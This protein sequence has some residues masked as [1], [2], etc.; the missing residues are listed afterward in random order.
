MRRNSAS[1]AISSCLC[2]SKSWN[3]GERATVI[4]INKSYQR[5]DC[6][7]LPSMALESPLPRESVHVEQIHVERSAKRP[8]LTHRYGA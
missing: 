5:R 6:R 1:Q 4:N 3:A 7:E 2:Y 8:L